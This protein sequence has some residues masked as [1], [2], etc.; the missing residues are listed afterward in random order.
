MDTELKEKGNS[1]MYPSDLE[2]VVSD[3]ETRLTAAEENIQGRTNFKILWKIVTHQYRHEIV[4]TSSVYGTT[5]SFVCEC[6]I[7]FLLPTNDITGM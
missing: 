5:N 3:H 2:E 6:N 7:F 1:D 4:D